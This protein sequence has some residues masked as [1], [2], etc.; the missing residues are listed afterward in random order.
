MELFIAHINC[1]LLSSLLAW[2]YIGEKKTIM[3]SLFLV[4]A[5][6]WGINIII[7]LV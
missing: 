4:A 7:R 1:A 6:L 3:G 2:I 5:I